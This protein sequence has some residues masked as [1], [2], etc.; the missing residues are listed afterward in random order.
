MKQLKAM[1]SRKVR[2]YETRRRMNGRNDLNSSIDRSGTELLSNKPG[3][4]S[5]MSRIT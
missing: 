3:D 5:S 4:L 2:R 1:N